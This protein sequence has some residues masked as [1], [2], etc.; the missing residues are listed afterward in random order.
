M[1]NTFGCWHASYVVV[2]E[3]STVGCHVLLCGRFARGLSFI[4]SSGFA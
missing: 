1:H 4:F 2:P 3:L